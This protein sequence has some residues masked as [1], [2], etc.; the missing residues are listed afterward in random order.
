M[1]AANCADRRRQSGGGCSGGGI[2]SAAGYRGS[3]DV[4]EAIKRTNN[5]RAYYAARRNG[6]GSPGRIKVGALHRVVRTISTR[7]LEWWQM[8]FRALL[9]LLAVPSLYAQTVLPGFDA[10]TLAGRKMSMPGAVHGH[11]ALLIVGFTHASG[12]YCSDWAR[13]LAKEFPGNDPLERYNIVFLED[14]PR[15]VR[16]MAK[17]GIKGSVPNSEYDHYLTVTEHEKQVQAAVH[18]ETPDDAYLILLGPEGTIRWTFHGAVAD[19]PVRQIREL[20]K[21]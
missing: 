12:P 14:A 9:L 8:A 2:L 17:S 10:E 21:Q 4:L 11:N 3:P 13:R 19:G 1:P 16:G 5:L 15:L 6:A 18:F 7:A 20:L